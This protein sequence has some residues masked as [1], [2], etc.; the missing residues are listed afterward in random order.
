M[1]GLGVV[2]SVFQWWNI[3]FEIW[4]QVVDCRATDAKALARSTSQRHVTGV[5]FQ[6][7]TVWLTQLNLAPFNSS[8]SRTFFIGT[9]GVT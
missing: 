1:T 7:S 3:E 9:Q 8:I 6:R 2:S 4:S 5:C